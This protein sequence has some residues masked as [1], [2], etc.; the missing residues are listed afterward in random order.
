ME[1]QSLRKGLMFAN[2]FVSEPTIIQ[3]IKD[4]QLQDRKLARISEHISE[5]LDFRMENGVLYFCGVLDVEDMRNEIMIKAH[6]ARGNPCTRQHK[7]VLELEGHILMEYE[8]GDS[9]FC[10]PM[11][12]LLADKGRAF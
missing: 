8:K 1:F 11:F 10:V 12:D 4:N 2:M 9:S 6:T 5:P 7:D 3:R